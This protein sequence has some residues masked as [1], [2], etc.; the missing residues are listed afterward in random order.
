[1]IDLE[2]LGTKSD[3]AVL[4]LG[5]VIFNREEILKKQLWHFNL[6]EQLKVKRSVTG[7]TLTW[8]MNQSES[9][10]GVFA[11]CNTEGIL[12]RQFVESFD[13]FI[14]TQ[15]LKVW[16]NGASFDVPIIENLL[17]QAGA[18]IP[19]KFWD[20]RCYRTMKAMFSIEIGVIRD[21]VAHDALDDAI[22]QT[23]CIQKYLAENPNRD[24]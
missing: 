14:G 10:R 23:K 18:Q 8:W 2:T 3:T 5:A 11:K 21:G 1:M 4:S 7:D 20:V 15:K 24:K 6:N 16:S 22:F 12:A 19:W 9:A 17:C 13:Q